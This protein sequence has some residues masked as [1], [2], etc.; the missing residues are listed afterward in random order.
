MKIPQHII[1]EILARTDMV[2][3]VS[4]HVSLR[5]RGQNYFGLCPFH[6]E[7]T[8]S[9]SVNPAKGIFHC[10]GCKAGGNAITFLTL[11]DNMSFPEAVEELARRTGVEVPKESRLSEKE[12][13]EQEY[14][15]RANELAQEYFHRTL[16]DGKDPGA[17][18]AWK[19]LQSRSI[20]KD[21][22]NT[23]K[24]GY[25]PDRWDG[26][27]NVATAKKIPVK[28]LKR[29]GLIV[30]KESE[31][32][33]Y[34]RFRHRVM[35]SIINLSGK[36][37][38]FGG[39]T[40]SDDPDTPKYLNSPDTPVFQKGNLLYGIRQ[41]RSAIR[42]QEFAILV[43][44]YTDTLALW[45]AG[46]DQTVATLGTA[47]TEQQ[48]RLL[49][50]YCRE[51]VLTF[52][53]DDAGLR[54]ALRAGDIVLSQGLTPRIMV[55]PEGE[56]PDSFVRERGSEV[57]QELLGTAP[58]FLEFKWKLAQDASPLAPR[59]KGN[60]IRWVLESAA[61]IPNELDRGI[62][63]KDLAEHTGLSETTL[64]KELSGIRRTARPRPDSERPA[65]LE[66]FRV[67]RE[68]T[69]ALE[70][71]KILIQHPELAPKAFPHWET[72]GIT[73]QP[74]R[75]LVQILEERSTNNMDIAQ[76]EVI[77]LTEDPVLR[78]WIAEAVVSE[79]MEEPEQAAQDCLIRMQILFKESQISDLLKKIKSAETANHDPSDHLMKISLIRQDIVK[80]GQQKLWEMS[81]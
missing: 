79:V 6:S 43:E 3:L 53:G 66:Q 10:F 5:R 35:F 9:F 17:A 11:H 29:A 55:M 45:I 36:V 26:L 12:I 60:R 71:L 64:A 20:P 37:V 28:I 56:D 2:E 13:S 72:S 57:F 31:R 78:N 21:V 59:E 62:V 34:D 51:V 48:A 40:L 14:L 46:F 27:L 32:G 4:E 7:K 33:Y 38:G 73:S 54:A 8:P 23:H 49:A 70:L 50:R 75:E 65:Q 67:T 80:L 76:A 25:A 44:G 69:P 81:V 74:L 42:K 68:D 61:R 16:M 63:I 52:D 22:I 1:E 77:S 15:I 24:I 41:A 19:F 39:R 18:H 58:Q 47:F 30:T